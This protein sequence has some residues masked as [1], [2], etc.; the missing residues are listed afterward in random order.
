MSPLGLITAPA[1]LAATVAGGAFG[2]A[3]DVLRGARGLLESDDSPPPPPPPRPARNGGPTE[4][5]ARKPARRPS[6]A[7]PPHEPP[8][9]EDHVD[10]GAVVVA[11]VA[12][13][14][15]EDG[16]GAQLDI[17]EPWDGYDR[18]TA[19][20]IS[21]ALAGA[22]REAV[23]AVQLYEAVGKGRDSVLEAA[24]RRL[25]DLTPPP[26]QNR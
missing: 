21:A 23:A 26:K 12:E 8:R 16:A 24:E 9:E 19:E 20:E 4:A 18:M 7:S 10:E 13:A 3:I 11:E 15:A 14:G 22:S 6:P 5:V 25:H 2:I 17:E 1:R